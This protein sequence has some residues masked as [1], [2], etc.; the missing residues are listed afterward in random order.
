MNIYNNYSNYSAED[1][2][3]DE[4][5]RQAIL[6][7]SST[8]EKYWA[9]VR[10]MHPELSTH[11]DE[12]KDVLLAFKLKIHHLEPKELKLQIGN[13]IRKSAGRRLSISAYLKTV[14]VAVTTVVILTGVYVFGFRNGETTSGFVKNAGESLFYDNHSDT[15]KTIVLADGSQVVLAARA[16]IR[17]EPEFNLNDRKVSLQGD[18]FFKVT[19]DSSRPFYVFCG[20]VETKVLGTSFKIQTDTLCNQVHVTVQSGVVAVTTPEDVKGKVVGTK[21]IVVARN[22]QA[23]YSVVTGSLTRSIT[24]NP[25]ESDNNFVSFVY[26]AKPVYEVFEDLQTAYDIHVLYDRN[27]VANH[28]FSGD[29]EGKTLQEKIRIVCGA[30]EFK[31]EIEDGIIRIY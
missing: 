4:D 28:F 2:I 10:R 5:F 7:P 9:E 21:T 22:Q 23:D 15:T 19:S 17:V 11:M 3:W 25:A 24:A 13:A 30:M 29:L 12:A 31:Y 27:S 8:S 14:G 16:G 26:N 20:N 18:A 6:D 1:F